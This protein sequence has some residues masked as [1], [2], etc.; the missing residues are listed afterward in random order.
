MPVT[1]PSDHAFPN[2]RVYR[3]L[4]SLQLGRGREALPQYLGS[5]FRGVFAS[6]FR[7]VVCIT[8]APEC[9]GCLLLQRCSYPY[10]FETPPPPHIAE[11]LQKRFRQAPRPYVLEVPLTYT[12]DAELELGLILVGKAIDFLPYFIYVLQSMGQHGLGRAR[13]PYRLR[14]V[15][16]GSTVDGS[17]VFSADENILKDG[18]RALTLE[19][20]PRA[21]D[22]ELSQVTLEFLTPLRMKKYGSYDQEE[23][24]IE[25]AP[26]MD[27]LL[28]R[29]EALSFFHCGC[30]W[31]HDERL[32]AQARDVRVV[33]RALSFQPLERYSN[34]QQRKLPLHG[35]VGTITVAGQLAE[36]L[37]FL[38]M[39]EYLH[40]GAGTAF[41]L[42]RYRLQEAGRRLC[43]S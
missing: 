38:R 10:I 30:A 43:S 3:F 4:L 19:S 9:Q 36:F 40:I 22:E 37:P 31:E 7:R 33:K 39:G 15:T 6:S 18:F 13:V 16:D 1:T 5:T 11:T 2:L 28:G 42:G 34:R 32:R 20:S 25:F 12:G 21:G 8:G 29:I 14:T 26:L 35:Y 24:D 17:L 27:L 23:T 41:G